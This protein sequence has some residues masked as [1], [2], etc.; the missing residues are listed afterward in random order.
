MWSEKLAQ[1]AAGFD[2]I[3]GIQR[4]VQIV[5]DAREGRTVQIAVRTG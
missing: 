2:G 1:V 4:A 5:S 3:G